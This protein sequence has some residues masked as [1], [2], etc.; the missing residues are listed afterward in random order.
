MIAIV[1]GLV[2]LLPVFLNS[3][4]DIN[5]GA[6]ILLTEDIELFLPW[7][8]EKT[9]FE[10]QIL[11]NLPEGR[12]RTRITAYYML[13]DI[14]YV[15][16]SRISQR[17]ANELLTF[18]EEYTELTG[19]DIM[20]MIMTHDLPL[21][22][23]NPP[24]ERV[25]GDQYIAP[26]LTEPT[27]VESADQ[28]E[29]TIV[30]STRE[31]ESGTMDRSIIGI[32]LRFIGT[33]NEIDPDDLTDIVLTKDGTVIENNL[34]YSG[35]YAHG[36]YWNREFTDFYFVFD[37]ENTETGIYALTGK[38][39]G[40]D[41]QVASMLVETYPPGD[42]PANPD[43][44]TSAVFSGYRSDYFDMDSPLGMLESF[45]L[46]FSGRQEAFDIADLTDV[47]LT[48]DGEEIDFEIAHIFRYVRVIL[49]DELMTWFAL[50]F[51]DMINTPGMYQIS[52][53][54][55]GMPFETEETEVGW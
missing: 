34:T 28:L 51:E 10:E 7:V 20:L 36:L 15:L 32:I 41:L 27:P 4:P 30:A 40:V 47:K 37:F 5:P 16:D 8:V 9:F 26:L 42:T 38:Y 54:Y 18:L 33:F 45:N 25:P 39:K 2:N 48:L 12:A 24:V 22:N 50:V 29:F 11:A 23:P 53:Y 3:D 49:E 46:T 44:F 52:G 13:R 35:E 31:L 55:R 6:G 43:D 1:I 17:E 19:N 21:D 14:G